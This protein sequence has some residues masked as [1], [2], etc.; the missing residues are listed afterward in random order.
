[1]WS[2][3]FCGVKLS[4]LH[5][6]PITCCQE[7]N[8][9]AHVSPLSPSRLVTSLLFH[10]RGVYILSYVKDLGPRVERDSFYH[11]Q[12]WSLSNNECTGRLWLG[13]A[14]SQ[15][16]RARCV[17]TLSVHVVIHR[18]SIAWPIA[19]FFA[20]LFRLRWGL[21]SAWCSSRP[22]FCSTFFFFFRQRV[23]QGCR[24]R[25]GVNHSLHLRCFSEY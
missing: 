2:V 25:A 3:L 6:A 21:S 1:M 4:S 20:S 10:S 13:H 17:S 14:N 23:F 15:C 9:D 16:F 12:D 11:F 19:R 22:N 5:T 18:T 24:V 8:F 7:H